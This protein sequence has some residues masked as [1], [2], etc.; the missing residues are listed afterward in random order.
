MD[1]V[2]FATNE[3][4]KG[5]AIELFEK[6]G[7]SREDAEKYIVSLIEYVNNEIEEHAEDLKKPISSIVNFNIESRKNYY[8][9]PCLRIMLLTPCGHIMQIIEVFV[10]NTTI[11]K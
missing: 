4:N 2:D 5:K 1:C 7:V 10:S 9:F 11:I 8:I 6:I 3:L